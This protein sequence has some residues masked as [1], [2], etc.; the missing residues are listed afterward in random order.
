MCQY[1]HRR[2]VVHAV[3]HYVALRVAIEPVEGEST[4]R[5]IV[6][7][8]PGLIA[9]PCRYGGPILQPV[10]QRCWGELSLVPVGHR[11]E[12]GEGAPEEP[13]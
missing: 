7:S 12:E 8:S 13:C 4:P 11:G 5:C 3:R 9:G 10:A 6:Y 2:D 1:S